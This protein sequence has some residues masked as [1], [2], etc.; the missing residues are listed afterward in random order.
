MLREVAP[1]GAAGVAPAAGNIV[2]SALGG[3][4]QA[5]R[6][7]RHQPPT[8][9]APDN[10]AISSYRV[11]ATR[12]GVHEKSAQTESC[13]DAMLHAVDTRD[14][15]GVLV[16]EDN[17]AL[18]ALLVTLLGE[19]GYRTRAVAGG[20]AALHAIARR[21]PNVIVLDTQMRKMSGEEFAR[22]YHALPP[23]HAPI[24]LLTGAARASET[25]GRIGAAAVI[26]KPF[27]LDDL[28]AAV[29]RSTVA[30]VPTA[31]DRPSASF[32]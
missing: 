32:S 17:A 26:S 10:V 16:V 3:G 22:I 14:R 15:G 13:P 8:L 6:T 5:S 2:A 7:G 31:R 1:A 25:G 11:A 29:G 18:R 30:P 19:E 4:T 28:I 20:R 24:V 21:A 12:E 27:D 9:P 23:P